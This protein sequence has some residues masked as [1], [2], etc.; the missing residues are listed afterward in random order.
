MPILHAHGSTT[1]ACV[2]PLTDAR[3]R[4]SG[5][6]QGG[7]VTCSYSMSPGYS[8]QDFSVTT[9]ATA[10]CSTSDQSAN[11]ADGQNPSA[12]S[13]ADVSATPDT[14]TLTDA[15]VASSPTDSGSQDASA[16]NGGGR[17]MLL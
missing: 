17:K 8:S 14:S 12:T 11:V 16:S 10:V 9:T 5:S 6:P 1:S 7:K 3:S 2:H 13:D 4:S 15:D